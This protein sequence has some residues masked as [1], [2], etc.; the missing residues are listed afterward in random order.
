MVYLRL[1]VWIA[2]NVTIL[3]HSSVCTYCALKINNALHECGLPEFVFQLSSGG[4]GGLH[5]PLVVPAPV[6]PSTDVIATLL[7]IRGPNYW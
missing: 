6:T 3:K 5:M 1:L 2:G 7:R 4:P